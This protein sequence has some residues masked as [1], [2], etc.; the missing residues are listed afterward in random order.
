MSIII[1]IAVLGVLLIVIGIVYLF[2]TK[3][4]DNSLTYS[5]PET[6]VAVY[7]LYG[8][9][10]FLFMLAVFFFFFAPSLGGWGAI[11]C[12]ALSIACFVGGVRCM[13]AGYDAFQ[14]R[15]QNME[16]LAKAKAAHA[17]HERNQIALENARREAKEQAEIDAKKRQLEKKQMDANYRLI[18]EDERTRTIEH[19]T[20]QKELQLRQAFIPK[21][22][23][24]GVDLDR[25]FGINE[26]EHRTEIDLENRW[27]E[28][29]QDSNAADLAQIGDHLV[30]KKLRQELQNAR[31]ERYAI[32]TGGDPEELKQE[33]LSDYDKFIERLEA[34]IDERETGHL[35]SEDRPAPRKIGQAAG[36]SRPD[37]PPETDEDSE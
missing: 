22:M 1:G 6:P 5:N 11:G 32:K 4:T 30:I 34:K 21:A 26:H 16:A 33:L 2:S 3:E 9:G 17:D 23:E 12:V 28:I 8:L 19:R 13:Q 20:K 24:K 10:V 27:K 37:Y 36:D 14:K 31:R 29:L 7:G 35:L 18:D 25:L 15:A